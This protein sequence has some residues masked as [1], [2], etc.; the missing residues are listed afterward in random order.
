MKIN[1]KCIVLI[2]FILNFFNNNFLAQKVTDVSFEAV[3]E[4]INIY[5]TLDS[6][7]DSEYEITVLLKR[8]SI[9][10]FN[11]SP[12]EISGSVGKGRF[13]EGKKTVVWTVSEEEMA[14]FDGDDFYFEIFVNKI[15]PSK[16]IPWYYY[17]G[18]AV[19]G[20]ATAAVLLLTGN[21]NNGTTSNNFPAPPGRP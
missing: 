11:Y 7:E 13:S 14:I 6:L 20:G 21:N 18:T 17:V 8:L 12:T 15:K 16:G 3:G 4:Q 1:V 10:S 19:V 2:F 9:P 5:Y